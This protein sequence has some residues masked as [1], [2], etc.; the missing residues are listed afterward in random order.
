M[1]ITFVPIRSDKVLT[2]HRQGDILT[3]NGESFDFAP[4]PDGATLPR[5]AVDC[6]WLSGPV[7]RQQGALHLSILLPHGAAAPVAVRFPAPVLDPPDGPVA[8]PS[9]DAEKPG[10]DPADDQN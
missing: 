3:I 5:E 9:E 7:E 2:L 1:K 10:K 4:L 8:L 6:P